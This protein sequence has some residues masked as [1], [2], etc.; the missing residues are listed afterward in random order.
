MS[1][2]RL[3]PGGFQWVDSPNTA[4]EAGH[5]RRWWWIAG[6][7]AVVVV[8][9][10]AGI[11]AWRSSGRRLP[12]VS[13]T[14]PSGPPPIGTPADRMVGF[15]L[16]HP[17]VEGWKITPADL[18]LPDGIDVA[19]VF[20]THGDK[21][22]ILA[23]DEPNRCPDDGCR[24]RGWVYGLNAATG[25]VLFSPVELPDYNP[26]IDCYGNGPTTAICLMSSD[27]LPA[28]VI[29]LEHG[30]LL[31]NGP[32]QIKRNGMA[33]LGAHVLGNNAGESRVVAIADGKGVYGIGGHAETTWFVPG[34]GYLS[35]RTPVDGDQ[36]PVSP[37][38]TQDGAP[39]SEHHPGGE[40]V[41][42]VIDGTDMTPD[43]P[44]G[45]TL[46]S[47]TTYNGGFA[48]IA[49]ATEG[50]DPANEVLLYDTTGKLLARHPAGRHAR[51]ISNPAMA[52]V[53][54]D[55][56][57]DVY[58]FDGNPVTRLPVHALAADVYPVGPWLY[59]Y[60]GDDYIP[61]NLH[62]GQRGA[63]Y[64]TPVLNYIGTDGTILLTNNIRTYTAIDIA[65]GQQLWKFSTEDGVD[66]LLFKVGTHIIQATGPVT[67]G[68][69]PGEGWH[70][71]TSLEAPN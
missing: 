6:V 47:A 46:S 59:V 4:A 2:S 37:L 14:A 5:R 62:T 53:L 41:F 34:S 7:L 22:F 19:H 67:V 48:V 17:L 55:D 66:R 10:G 13:A 25:K 29:D 58:T 68:N 39:P 49:T 20:A 16:A 65:T 33:P 38:I 69:V 44:P 11:T 15:S 24:Y 64:D 12:G 40:R 57:I 23:R 60:A 45:T 32:T 54:S 3:P 1:G 36:L 18:G 70:T 9:A 56:G 28:W 27:P 50:W 8:A 71:L 35:P 26:G 43:A 61:W 42:S 31:Y 30:K 21:A 63:P 51:M 52:T